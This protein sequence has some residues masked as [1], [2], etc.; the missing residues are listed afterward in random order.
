MSDDAQG[1]HPRRRLRHAAVSGHA[2][3]VEAAAAGLR[4]ADD[5]LPAVDADAGRHPRHPAH[6]DAA[7]TRR[8]SR[9]CSATA[10]SGASTSRYA[11][12][13]SPDG[14]AQAF[15]IG[16]DFVGSDPCGAGARRQHLLR[17]RPRSRSST[18]ATRDADGRDGLR[19][20]GRRSRALRRRRVRRRRAACCQLEEKPAQPKSRYA[21][22]GLY[23]YDKRV[24][25]I[26]RDAQAVGARR[27]R[28]HRRQPR[29]P[30]ARRRSTCEVMGRGMAWL[31]TGTHE[32]LLEAAQFIETIERR[33]GLKIACPEEIAYRLGYIDAR[34][35]RA[36]SAQRDGEERLRPV[37][38]RAAARTGRPDDESHADRAAGRAADRAA[39]VRRRRAASSSRA[40]TR[41]RSQRP[42]STP[43][44]VQDNHSRSR[45]GVLRGLHYQIEHAQ[46]KLVRVDRRRGV[47]RRRRPA[48]QLADLRP[49]GRRDAVGREQA[50]AVDAARVRARLPRAV[51]ATRSSS[52]RRPTTGIRSTSARCCG[53]IRRSASPGRSTA[54]RSLDAEGR[55]GHAARA[56]EATRDR[57]DRR[58]SCVTGAAR[59]GRLRARARCCR[60]TA[61]SSRSIARR[62]TSP[63][64]TRSSR[65]V[66]DAQPDV[67]VN[68]AAYTAVDRA[69]T[70]A[71]RARS[72]STRAR[73][74]V[75]AE[76]AKRARRAARPL[77]DRLRVRRHA[78]D[79]VRR[80]RADRRRSTSTARASSRASARSRRRGAA[81]AR[82]AHELGLRPA[83]Q[84]FPADDPQARGASATSCASSPTRS[85]RRTGRARSPRRRRRWSRAACATLA[86]RAGPL[87]PELDR[88][89]RRGTAS[90]A[91]SSATRRSRGSTPIATAEYPTPARR[92]AYGVL[93]TD[94]FR[95]TRSASRC[96]L[97]GCAGRLS[98][99]PSGRVA[100]G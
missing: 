47:R 24:L 46:G 70:R 72:R 14:L 95:A 22:T 99:A 16:R 96:R 28:D 90:R 10:R 3:R 51:G 86:E 74:G 12:Q 38:A 13:P 31:D 6:L 79:A 59:P 97:A 42:A 65:D 18:R 94:R 92:P 17:P 35:A 85:A 49:L 9:S 52:T 64:P 48:P 1:H 62:S 60:R 43:T 23:F 58:R 75:L 19:L 89:R 57:R 5:L 80:G 71:R 73:R 32:S 98:C 29:V 100:A 37:P 50:D 78:R 15:I 77:L 82:A 25:D 83:R 40:G 53:T 88:G 27:A 76:E 69:E 4:Q 87:S 55:R 61:T 84:E 11:V 39:R 41:A 20:S 45:R 56:A 36:R 63:T 26:A 21:V 33:Q 44:F 66:R 67:I 93:A 91:R 8:A 68:A 2:G 7:R 30:R 81:R 54:R 34:A